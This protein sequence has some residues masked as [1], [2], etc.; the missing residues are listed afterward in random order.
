MAGRG[1]IMPSHSYPLL[2]IPSR[3]ITC[4]F[5]VATEFCIWGNFPHVGIIWRKF[6]ARKNF[7]KEISV[8]RI[9]RGEFLDDF[10]KGVCSK[11][12]SAPGGEKFKGGIFNKEYFLTL[13]SG[14]QDSGY[15]SFCL[16]QK[17]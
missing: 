5:F 3:C 7:L 12:G 15:R 13:M 6:S 14:E 8:W 10:P 1:P 2:S 4:F 17:Y 9:S 16:Q 11:K